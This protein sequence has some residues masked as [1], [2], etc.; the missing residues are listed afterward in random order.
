MALD[1]DLISKYN[2]EI[3]IQV[4]KIRQEKMKNHLKIQVGL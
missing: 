4:M 3:H 2:R 1:Y